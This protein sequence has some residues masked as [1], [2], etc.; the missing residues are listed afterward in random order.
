MESEF[1]EI[2]SWKEPA[3]WLLFKCF[4]LNAKCSQFF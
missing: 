4:V 3:E 1:S 2:A